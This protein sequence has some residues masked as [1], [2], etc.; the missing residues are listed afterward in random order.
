M[1]HPYRCIVMGAAGRDFHVF[2]S[3]LR[4][5]PTFQVV[6][7]TATQIPF[8]VERKFPRS[9]AG[10]GYA[11]DIPIHDESELTDLIRDL[12]VDFV[13]F[14]YSD[15]AHDEVM[16]K[17]CVVQAAGA[18][19]IMLGPEH[20]Q[21]AS[22]KPVV[23]VT[24]TRTGAGKSPLTQWLARTLRE[25]DIPAAVIRHPMP[26]GNLTMQ[27]VQRFATPEDL[28]DQEC[29]IEE[30]EEY[31]PYVDMGIPIYA[32]VDYGAILEQAAQHAKIVLWDGGNNDFSFIRPDLD[33]V[34]VDAL[35]AGHE[36]R[37]FPGEVNF[38]RADVLVISKSQAADPGSIIG[39]RERARAVNPSA[40]ICT[41][42]LEIHVD[43]PSRIEGRRVLVI[44]DG[45]TVTHGGMAYGAGWVA[46]RRHRAVPVDAR[47]YAVGT[48]KDTFTAYPHLERVLPAMGYSETQRESLAE[49]INAC[50]A[51]ENVDFVLDASPARLERMMELDVPLIR[52]SYGFVQLDGPD[53]MEMVMDVVDKKK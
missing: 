43:D 30:R 52:V 1:S 48:I 47:P 18:S 29:T 51:A 32:G 38:R 13:F 39:I 20:T 10:Q 23:S 5:N 16:H 46:A 7:F 14:A 49:T 35:R 42:D 28:A 3:F 9:L 12:Q 2:L 21:L 11:D 41:A 26:Y 37:Y 17:A 19:F 34:V 22:E 45:P 36:T 27:R 15:I 40:A 4:D 53:L 24:A 33:I 6:A 25:R 8:I 31:E 50:C 44:E